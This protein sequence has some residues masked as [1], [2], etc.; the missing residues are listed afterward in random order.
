MQ[1][2][3]L[4]HWQYWDKR[5]Q[6]FQSLAFQNSST[7]KAV[8]LVERECSEQLS[9][10]QL[11]ARLNQFYAK[12]S[13][14]FAVW[15]FD[16]ELLAEGLYLTNEPSYSGD[17]C[18]RNLRGLSNNEAQSFFKTQTRPDTLDK[19]SYCTSDGMPE[20]LTQELA[21]QFAD[22]FGAA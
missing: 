19:I 4:L 1:Y 8:S 16:D 6:N 17:E 20:P 22:T 21:D 15:I 9:Q 12:Y 10:G 2:I 3:R 13:P 18:H 7:S 14:C 5:K 11:C